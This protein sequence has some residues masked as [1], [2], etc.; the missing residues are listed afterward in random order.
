MVQFLR[1]VT[2]SKTQTMA[3]G[4][5]RRAALVGLYLFALGTGYLLGERGKFPV[6]PFPQATSSPLARLGIALSTQPLT[7][8]PEGWTALRADVEA[9]LAM[10]KPEPRAVLEL[11]VAVRGLASGGTPAWA[12]AEQRCKALRW[13]RC[14]RPA[15]EALAKRSR[16]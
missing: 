8:S 13:P 7:L 2:A 14:D 9:V 3:P 1:P 6:R 10:Q 4:A 16:P 12:E 15:L 5:A 11:V